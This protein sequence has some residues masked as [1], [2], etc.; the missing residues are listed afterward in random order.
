MRTP[1]LAFLSVALSLT[2]CVPLSGSI[3]V[4]DHRPTP[5]YIYSYADGSCWAD[6]VWYRSCPWPTGTSFGYYH[7][8][9]GQYYWEPHSVWRFR[10]GQPPPWYWQRQRHRQHHPPHMKDPPH[11]WRH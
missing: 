8:Y 11:R 2:A 7:R 5:S 10:V 4:S 3:T 1:Y 9:G 6:G